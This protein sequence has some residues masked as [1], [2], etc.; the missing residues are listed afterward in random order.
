MNTYDVIIIGGGAAGLMCAH[1]LSKEEQPPETLIIE[2]K[3]SPGKKLLATGNGRCNYA[4]DVLDD[5]SYRGSNSLFAY[6]VINSFDKDMLLDELKSMGIMS[7]DIN[8]YYYPRSLQAGTVRSVLCSGIL[9]SGIKIECDTNVIDISNADHLYL[10]HTD[11][12]DYQAR[13]VVLATGG[14]SYSALGSDGSGYDIAKK[15]GHTITPLFP[16][17]TGLK[18]SGIDNK[19]SHGV[20]AKGVVR[21]FHNDDK[22]VES[23]GEIQFTNYG[24]SGIPIF[25]IS[26]YAAELLNQSEENI[27]LVIDLVP[28]YDIESLRDNLSSLI[29]KN[30]YKSILEASN[31]YIPDKLA[32]NLLKKC[33]IPI[34]AK[35]KKVT[36]DMIIHMTNEMKA[37]KLKVDDVCGFDMA[38]VTAGGV[39]TDEINNDTMESL[40]SDNLY[41]VGEIMDIDGNCGGY[42]LHFAFASAYMC[43]KSILSKF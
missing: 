18:T 29:E 14:M 16:A 30:R 43:A 9:Q 7:T 3:D 24:V 35:H 20:R 36:D 23:F 34:G 26:R 1:F 25:Q 42:N 27:Y 38:Q 15:L 22:A 13:C 6:N 33:G 12:D 21:L 28:E 11:K 8:G 17:L 37:L 40:I 32:E 19:L 10:V 5:E 39:S 2:H 4:N 41:F 31:A